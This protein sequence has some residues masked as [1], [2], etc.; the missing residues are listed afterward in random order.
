MYEQGISFAECFLSPLPCGF[1]KGDNTQHALLKF[2]ETCK[3]AINV[4]GFAGAPLMDL[5]KS[6]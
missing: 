2:L 3:A 5:S 6:L 1:R 4:A